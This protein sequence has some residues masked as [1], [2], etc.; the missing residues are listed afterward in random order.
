[1]AASGVPLQA[2]VL[3]P[4]G[5]ECGRGQAAAP[6]PLIGC[7][8]FDPAEGAPA[9]DLVID[10]EDLVPVEVGGSLAPPGTLP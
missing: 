1:M 2:G 8:V 6:I 4:E 7:C 10:G 5:S 9:A 3:C